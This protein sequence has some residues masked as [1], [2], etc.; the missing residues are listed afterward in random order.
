METGDLWEAIGSLDEAEALHALTRLY[1]RYE[2]RLEK[3]PDDAVAADFMKELG[4]V[5]TLVN[6]CNLNRR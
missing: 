2:E 6:D 4:L 3:N 5:L 1:G